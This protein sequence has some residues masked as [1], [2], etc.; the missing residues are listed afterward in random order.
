MKI[1]FK[2]WKNSKLVQ[3]VTIEDDSRETRTHK[4]MNALGE[5]CRTFDLERPMWLD[6]TVADFKESARA[7]FYADSFIEEVPFDY[8]E[9]EVLE[10][11]VIGEK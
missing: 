1:W 5:A 3:D 4:V 2:I 10:E 11:D 7:R 6:R 8:L 9:I